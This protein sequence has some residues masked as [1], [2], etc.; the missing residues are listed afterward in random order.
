MGSRPPADR[1]LLLESSPRTRS[2]LEN[3][4]WTGDALATAEP[5]G[6]LHRPGRTRA[7][8]GSPLWMEG[9]VPGLNIG[10][11]MDTGSQDGS[12]PHRS[13]PGGTHR[14]LLRDR[15]PSPAAGLSVFSAYNPYLRWER[16]S[17]LSPSVSR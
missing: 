3:V 1:G 10:Y 11:S 8:L 2:Q 17:I 16:T 7:P 14:R 4:C 15:A 9:R 5:E 6:L 12:K 13:P